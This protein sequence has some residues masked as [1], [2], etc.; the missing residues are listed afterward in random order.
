MDTL[1][2]SS[3]QF[4][5]FIKI[6]EKDFRFEESEIFYF[7]KLNMFILQYYFLFYF[8]LFRMAE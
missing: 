7:A 4:K 1:I 5:S 8:F 6:H 2:L 3:I